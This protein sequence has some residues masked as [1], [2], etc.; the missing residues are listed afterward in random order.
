MSL[1]L[2]EL[3]FV[4][5]HR[6]LPAEVIATRL[7]RSKKSIIGTLRRLG[8][9][10]PPE[11]KKVRVS[12]D[13][14]RARISSMVRIQEQRFF[15]PYDT[16]DAIEARLVLDTTLHP[17]DYNTVTSNMNRIIGS[18][19]LTGINRHKARPWLE[20]LQNMQEMAEALKPSKGIISRPATI[21]KVRVRRHERKT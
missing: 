5:E 15:P 21:T 1:S 16:L 2:L 14:E 4:K 20:K 13:P 9:Q 7:N 12:S 3:N 10:V 11:P 6:D 8:V 18:L 19:K 17:H